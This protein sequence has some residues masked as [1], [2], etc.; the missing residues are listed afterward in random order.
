MLLG[1][2]PWLCCLQCTLISS[3]PVP[4][5][6]GKSE[7]SPLPHPPG[8]QLPPPR[9]R[10]SCPF[11]CQLPGQPGLQAG[12][13]LLLQWAVCVGWSPVPH[14]AE[15]A[16]LGR[17]SGHWSTALLPRLQNCSAT[18]GNFLRS[19]GP[20]PDSIDWRKKGNFVTPVKNQVR[21]VCHGQRGAD[22]CGQVPQGA[23]PELLR[24]RRAPGQG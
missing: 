15:G 8:F 13:A 18:R 6:H 10:L 19:S 12:S 3:R 17:W 1:Q 22:G 21:S 24:A 9:L 7:L 5:A 11:C 2:L 23:P 16:V 14:P 4:A 20:Y